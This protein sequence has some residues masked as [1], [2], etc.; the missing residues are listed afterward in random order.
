MTAH[1]WFKKMLY[2]LAGQQVVVKGESFIAPDA[3]V[4]G[5]VTLENNTSIW[6]GTV[7]RADN[8]PVWIDENT[9]IQD[10]CVIHV[11][12]GY[13][14]NIGANVTVGHKVMLHGCTI[15]AGSLIGINSVIMNGAS[16]GESCVIGANSLIT[17]GKNIPPRSLVIGSPGKIVRKISD[18][19]MQNLLESAQ[20]YVR[21]I[22]LYNQKL[23]EM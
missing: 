12:P 4:I 9:N 23:M 3:A 8:E 17:E 13:P 5:S 7:V 18:R 16:I 2:A 6:F 19:E 11:D 10:G 14:V 21:K 22:K 1:P 20:I 15:G